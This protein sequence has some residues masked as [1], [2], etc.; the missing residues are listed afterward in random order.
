VDHR[1]QRVLKPEEA[2]LRHKIETQV[3]ATVKQAWQDFRKHDIAAADRAL[4]EKADS[5]IFHV[6]PARAASMRWRQASLGFVVIFFLGMMVVGKYPQIL[7]PP[8]DHRTQQGLRSIAAT[9]SASRSRLK[10]PG[11]TNTG[12]PKTLSVTNATAATNQLSRLPRP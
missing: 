2:E 11:I 8:I 5:E 1:T 7:K 6:P 10:P 9:N 3:A 12:A 4:G